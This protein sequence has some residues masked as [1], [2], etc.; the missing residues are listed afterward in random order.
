MSFLKY[1]TAAAL[2]VAATGVAPAEAQQSRVQ[3]GSLSCDISAG[4]SVIVGSNREISCLFFPSTP[5]GV[6]H[7]SGTITKLG[8]DLGVIRRGSLVWLVYAP[9]V[10]QNGALQGAY[11]GIAANA[12]LG[13]GLGAN[14]L[15][16]GFDGSIA[17]QPLS[18]EG[19]SGLNIAAGVATMRLRY[20]PVVMTPAKPAAHQTKHKAKTH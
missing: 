2:A 10:L 13:L 8:I 5:T 15:I 18:V 17:L 16:G 6:E 11:S 19:T 4:I 20:A 7:Y 12:T 9:T 3:A 14:I 1:L